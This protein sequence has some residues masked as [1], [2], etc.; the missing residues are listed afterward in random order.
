LVDLEVAVDRVTPVGSR[1]NLVVVDAE[2]WRLYFSR[3]AAMDLYRS[4]AAGPAAALTFVVD[5]EPVDRL[6]GWS[7]DVWAEGGVVI[8]CVAQRLVW[9]GNHWMESLPNRRVFFRLLAETWAGWDVQW[10]YDGLGD[11]AAYL[12]WIALWFVSMMRR[13]MSRPRLRPGSI[14]CFAATAWS[15]R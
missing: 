14:G 1:A 9:F 3:W 8:D 15:C 13:C 2:G 7:N 10:A 5:R 11:I 4:L 6:G 12:V